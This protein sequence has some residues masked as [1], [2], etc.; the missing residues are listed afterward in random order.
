MSKV[1]SKQ[2]ERKGEEK[3]QSYVEH[4]TVPLPLGIVDATG[5]LVISQVQSILEHIGDQSTLSWKH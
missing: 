5:L 4:R 2:E 3:L 1:R